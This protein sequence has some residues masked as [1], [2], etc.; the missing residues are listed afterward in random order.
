MF[1]PAFL[2][3]NLPTASHFLQREKGDSLQWPWALCYLPTHY[4]FASLSTCLSCLTWLH[5]Q[6]PSYCSSNT[7]G[8]LLHGVVFFFFFHLCCSLYLKYS[9]PKYPHDFLSHLLQIS[10]QILSSKR[11][12]P[13][14]F[15]IPSHSALPVLFFS[16]AIITFQHNVYFINYLL[17]LESKIPEW[18]DFCELVHCCTGPRTVLFTQ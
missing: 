3:P 15:K 10:V 18:K 7:P 2:S 4:P 8:V 12:L 5:W 6:W 1:S 13:W 17:S 16:T 14:H 9:S 11:R